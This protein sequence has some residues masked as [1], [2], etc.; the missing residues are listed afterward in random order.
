MRSK[1]L[2][3]LRAV[4]RAFADTTPAFILPDGFVALPKRADTSDLR[5]CGDHAAQANPPASDAGLS[6]PHGTD[7]IE[8]RRCRPLPA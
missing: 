3:S 1:L 4:L 7:R 2:Q 5:P 6:L 8:R